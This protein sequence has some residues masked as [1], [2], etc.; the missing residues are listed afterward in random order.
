MGKTAKKKLVDEQ[1][2]HGKLELVEGEGAKQGRVFARGEFGHAVNP[3][4]NKRLYRH[5]IWEKNFSRLQPNLESK[6]ILGE[7]D[8][9]TDGRTA[10]TRASHVITDLRLEGDIVLGEA[11]ILDT[12]KGRDL[13]AILAAG[14]PVGI[15]SRGYGSTKPG[16]DG[17]EEVQDDY[18]LMTFDFVAEPADP[19]AYPEVVFESESESNASMMFEGAT[20]EEEESEEEE[21]EETSDAEDASSDDETEDV[22]DESSDE[23]D[24]QEMAKRFAEKVLA[25]AGKKES[26]ENLREEFTSK[27]VERIT[28]LRSDVEK[29]VRK[30]LESDPELGAAKTVLAQIRETLQPL[31]LSED[32]QEIIAAKDAEIEVLRSQLD[33]AELRIGGMEELIEKLTEAAREAGYKYHLECL[34]RESDSDADRVREIVGDVSQYDSPDAL[35]DRVEEAHAEMAAFRIEEE[36]LEQ[37]RQAESS[38]LRNK[39]R[40]LA[41]SLEEALVANKDMALQIYAAKRLQ[42]HPQGAKILRMLER[43]G[44]QTKEQVDEMIEEF[45]EPER[46]VDDLEAIRARVRSRLQSGREYMEE[47]VQSA[48]RRG[49]GGSRNYNGLGASLADLKHLAGVRD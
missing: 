49:G 9:P 29:Q 39:N 8:H 7:L 43:S 32:V 33:E 21:S 4:A 20:I 47:D 25:D 22:D 45:R 11:E 27:I 36:R 12:S 31:F 5:S 24:E 18:R 42:T 28:A 13:K 1:V 26:V 15:S 38:R 40:Q 16:N 14:V 3:T 30:E 6:K 17:I 2:H 46:D 41:E 23:V 35:K 48:S 44:I 10:L 34:L 37:R 19:T